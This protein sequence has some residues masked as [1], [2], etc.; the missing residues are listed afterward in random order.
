MSLF[1]LISFARSP[2]RGLRILAALF[3]RD[4]QARTVFEQRLK[5]MAERWRAD[6]RVLVEERAVV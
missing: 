2:R 1:Y 6:R 5:E 4:F 3:K